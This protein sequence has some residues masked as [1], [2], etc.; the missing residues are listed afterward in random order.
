MNWREEIAL[1][2]SQAQVVEEWEP[3]AS[4]E[5]HV[6]EE[7]QVAHRLTKLPGKCQNIHGHSMDITLFLEV[8]VNEDGLAFDLQYGEDAILEFGAIKAL[9][10][11]WLKDN[12]DHHLM[13]NEEDEWAGSWTSTVHGQGPQVFTF[14]PG[15]TTWPGDPTTENIAR[16]IAQAMARA[17]LPV[18]RIH[19]D[20][21]DSNGVTFEQ[22]QSRI[23]L[24]VARQQEETDSYTEA[25]SQGQARQTF[26]E[27]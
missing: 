17:G 15:V 7:V 24:N 1:I 27:G 8:G 12:I 5:I 4:T 21:T 2:Y 6:S 3:M 14:L 9:F 10:R 26:P 16:W 19:I 13:L 11:S 25:A 18:S 22:V 23:A 20:E